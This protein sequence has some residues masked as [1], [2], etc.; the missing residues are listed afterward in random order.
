MKRCLALAV[1]TVSFGLLATTA[2]A[3]A[4]YKPCFDD[5]IFEEPAFTQPRFEEPVFEPEKR[6]DAQWEKPVFEQSLREKPQFEQSFRVVPEFEPLEFDN[7][8]TKAPVSTLPSAPKVTTLSSFE[9]KKISLARPL[10]S[11]NGKASKSSAFAP[12]ARITKS[13]SRLL[14]VSKVR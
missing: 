9:P 6:I 13:D 2:R 11:Q 1:L 14:A 10:V 3:Q 4:T 12:K 7:G 8:C 5:P